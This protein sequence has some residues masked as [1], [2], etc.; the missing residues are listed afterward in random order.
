MH[1]FQSNAPQHEL[2]S[3]DEGFK[4]RRI[5]EA[6]TSLP[7]VL[8]LVWSTHACFTAMLILL[9][10]AQGFMPAITV[11]IARS[12]IDSVVYGIIHHTISPLWVPLGLQ[13]IAGL[14]SNVLSTLST[15]VQQLLQERVSNVSVQT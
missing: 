15:I 5:F 14:A 6:F 4:L 7:R 1:G 10:V 3:K 9:N 11:L 12:V 2:Q 13:L 8:R